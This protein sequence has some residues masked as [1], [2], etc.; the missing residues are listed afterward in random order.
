MILTIVVAV[1]AVT[2]LTY[3]EHDRQPIRPRRFGIGL[4]RSHLHATNRRRPW[5][6]QLVA[7]YSPDAVDVI[8]GTGR[9]TRLSG[10]ARTYPGALHAARRARRQLEE[11][12]DRDRQNFVLR[13]KETWQTN[14]TV[15]LSTIDTDEAS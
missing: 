2:M 3:A 6:W 8:V 1:V 9:L 5:R 15:G 4:R 7:L 12:L 14:P 11:E 10:R 13:L